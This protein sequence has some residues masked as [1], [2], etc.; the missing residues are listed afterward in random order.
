M[1]TV[2]TPTRT[3]T[4][5]VSTVSSNWSAAFN[6]VV[7]NFQRR[8]GEIT[9]ITPSA[10]VGT[11]IVVITGT[12]FADADV[13]GGYVYINSNQYEGTYLVDSVVVGSGYVYLIIQAANLGSSTGGY[14]NNL[15]RT[16]YRIEFYL[17]IFNGG[18]YPTSEPVLKQTT[19]NTGS[20]ELNVAPALQNTLNA[21]ADQTQIFTNTRDTNLYGC[22]YLGWSERYE[23]G[24]TFVDDGTPDVAL[25]TRFYFN[26]AALQY[27][28]STG[29]NMFDYVPLIGNSTGSVIVPDLAK[30]GRFLTKF[31]E[32][33]YWEGYP[34]LLMFIYSEYMNGQ[35]L[36][37]N[38][39][40][41]DINGNAISDSQTNLTPAGEEA[42]NYM[43]IDS[44]FAANV[45]KVNVFVTISSTAQVTPPVTSNPNISAP[46]IPLQGFNGLILVG[47]VAASKPQS[48][49][50]LKAGYVAADYV[51]AVDGESNDLQV[52]ET[53]PVCIM[54]DCVSN[55]FYLKWLNTLGGFDYYMFSGSQTDSIK[56]R[57]TQTFEPSEWDIEEAERGAFELQNESQQR[58]TVG[59]TG[60]T[61]NDLYALKDLLASPVVYRV[62]T[63]G[64]QTRVNVLKGSYKIIETRNNV[65]DIELDVN[66]PETLIQKG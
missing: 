52:I 26:Y 9:N 50:Y 2:T 18:F 36:Q 44:S 21:I 40:L 43:Y 54:Q 41:K 14:V 63:G 37:R 17:T 47:G 31:A 25:N 34:F 3:T 5:G 19:S 62:E 61:S 38:Q 1:L 15:A 59:A 58:Y 24:A 8:D 49:N 28:S 55:P 65:S 11:A 33:K 6:P 48:Q 39:Y 57:N 22:Y 27:R 16:N 29:S 46:T 13:T 35:Q 10:S 23:G 4:L 32:P 45:S 20:C 51:T 12:A 60:V 53:L 30:V 7:F 56:T 66:Y 64:I 42:V